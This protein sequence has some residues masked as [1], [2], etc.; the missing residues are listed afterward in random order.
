MP[1]LTPDA[2]WEEGPAEAITEI[3]AIWT[4]AESEASAAT[5]MSLS[6]GDN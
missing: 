1:E 6:T 4:A 3:R 2:L 5:A